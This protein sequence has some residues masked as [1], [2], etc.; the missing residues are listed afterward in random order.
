MKKLTYEQ[1]K[2][3][4]GT[5]GYELISCEYENNVTPLTLKCSHGHTFVSDYKRIQRGIGCIH[6]SPTKKLTNEQVTSFFKGEGYE[7]LEPYVNANS[8]ISVK[9]PKGHVYTTKYSIFYTGKRC[10]HCYGNAK[11]TEN[12]YK[13]LVKS[14]NSTLL[15]CLPNGY[16]KIQCSEGHV[17][18][19]HRDVVKAGFK[20]PECSRIKKSHTFEFIKQTVEADGY[21]LLSTSYKSR[22]KIELECPKGHNYSVMFGDFLNKGVRCPR[23]FGG[24]S[25]AEKQ[26]I[27][28]VKTLGV[29]VIENDRSQIVNPL[30]GRYLELDAWMPSLNK[31]IELNGEYWHTDEKDKI[32]ECL[33]EQ[34]SIDLLVIKYSEWKHN[35]NNTLDRIRTFIGDV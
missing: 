4:I 11:K 5:K 12:D 24:T 26:L 21:K 19:T 1:V 29:T 2:I 23:C 3:T 8:K 31:A 20:C 16:L 22:R 25:K 17:Y 32:K 34:A 14:I 30:T 13:E 35:N 28:F 7:L 18:S 6:C 10:P 9:C 27:E 33:C 15:E